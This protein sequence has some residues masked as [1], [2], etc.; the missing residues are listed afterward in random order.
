[1]EALEGRDAT[2]VF[3][4]PPSHRP[5]L[6]RCSAASAGPRAND[7]WGRRKSDKPVRCT[8]AYVQDQ[9][10]GVR[11]SEKRGDHYPREL[12]VGSVRGKSKVARRTETISGFT[13]SSGNINTIAKL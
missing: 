6:C 10:R 5:R 4:L 8:Y 12:Q 1:M 13:N 7:G 9:F 2:Q 3:M 11:A